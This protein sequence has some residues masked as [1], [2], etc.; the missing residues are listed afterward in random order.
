MRINAK[1]VVKE[2]I[3]SKTN[4]NKAES[5]DQTRAN[6]ARVCS[7]C[8]ARDKSHLRQTSEEVPILSYFTGAGLLDL[9]FLRYNF[10]IVWRNENNDAFA[11]GFAH[12]MSALT[13][14]EHTINDNRS[15]VDLTT[16]QVVR[17]AFG[18]TG[19]PE[20][21][22]IV[23]G[24]PCPDFS[25]GG[26]NHG[27]YGDNGKLSNNYVTH[28]LGLR[29][30][31]FLFENVNGL[32]KTEKHK[33]FFDKI[34]TRLKTA[35]IVDH[36]VLNALDFGVPQN[37]ERVFLLGFRKD[38]LRK[39]MDTN[40]IDQA[41][42]WFPWPMN[43]GYEGAKNKYKWPARV[44]FGSQPEKP[45]DIPE[46]LMVGTHICTEDI[47][48]LANSNDRFNPKSEKFQLID[49]GDDTRK[50][51]KRLHRWRYSPTA[52]Y[53]NNEVHL[54]PAEARRLSVREV[55]RLQTVP[56]E[57]ELPADL[58]LG[59]K[60]K[61]IGNG[62]PVDLAEAVAGAI[63]RVLNGKWDGNKEICCWH[64]AV[65]PKHRK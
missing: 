54:H 37:R 64:S 22:G 4:G 39:R 2:V 7:R 26:K 1:K 10:N 60:F 62:V 51:F 63:A 23:G 3:D 30:A 9:G 6:L 16:R 56:D 13:G 11:R 53:G 27:E 59:H 47:L 61:M 43:E 14:E 32:F 35:Y 38:W 12:A 5:H 15:I 55:S 45:N 29:P 21:F 48:E 20:T 34:V 52:A 19:K 8:L 18:A 31:F 49:E 44:P 58:A 57:Y 36:R 28:I 25:N 24:P 17:K 33:A 65:S 46:R 41:G 50:S 42:H 40:T